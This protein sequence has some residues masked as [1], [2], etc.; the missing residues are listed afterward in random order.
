[1]DT[2]LHPMTELFAQLGLPSNPEAIQAFIETNRPRAA[3]LALPDAPFWTSSQA[4]FL[5][6]QVQN[7]A[8]WAGVI[9]ALDGAFHRG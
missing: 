1:M 4:E 9:D 7:D 8:D 3:H 2:H 5:R 6:D